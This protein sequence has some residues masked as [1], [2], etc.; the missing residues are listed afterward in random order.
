MILQASLL[1]PMSI[2]S[3]IFSL[4]YIGKFRLK[5]RLQRDYPQLTF[6]Q[7]SRK[8]QSELVFVEELPVGEAF[9][10]AP[11]E[12]QTDRSS[13]SSQSEAGE[14]MHLG[15]TADIREEVSLKELYE[16]APALK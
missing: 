6:H 13:Q 10:N 2:L 4:Q 12:L 15:W 14:E 7:P 1:Q 11:L 9:K 8:N 5:A 16:V 3:S